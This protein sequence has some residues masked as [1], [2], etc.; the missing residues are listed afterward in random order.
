MPPIVDKPSRNPITYQGTAEKGNIP[1]RLGP[2]R[3]LGGTPHQSTQNAK[4]MLMEVFRLSGGIE[5]MVQW[6]KK[7][8]REF[9]PTYIRAMVPKAL[10]LPTED[11]AITIIVQARPVPPPV[12]TQLA[13][14][15]PAT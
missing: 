14:T 4:A 7:N 5:G 2:P 10:E 3:R 1:V 13:S 12:C 6:A 15:D 8:P 9:Y 11:Q